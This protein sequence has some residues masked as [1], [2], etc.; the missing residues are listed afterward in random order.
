MKSPKEAYPLSIELLCNSVR[1][2]KKV[3]AKNFQDINGLLDIAIKKCDVVQPKI[4][5]KVNEILPICNGGAI[6]N[7]SFS[8]FIKIEKEYVLKPETIEKE[9]IKTCEKFN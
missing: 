2:F 1:I 6:V 4:D 3:M 9:N 5:F 7:A 8:G